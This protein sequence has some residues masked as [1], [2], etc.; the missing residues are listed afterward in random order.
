MGFLET[1]QVPSKVMQLVSGRANIRTRSDSQE[2]VC[3]VPPQCMD[4]L[5]V[6]NLFL[7]NKSTSQHLSLSYSSFLAVMILKDTVPFISKAPAI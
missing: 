7:W 4:F 6:L 1:Q 5:K 3:P 2:Q